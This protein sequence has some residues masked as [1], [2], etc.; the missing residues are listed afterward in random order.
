MDV[1]SSGRQ[2]GNTK[3]LD[4]VVAVNAHYSVLPTEMI[5]HKYEQFK[6]YTQSNTYFKLLPLFLKFSWP[7]LFSF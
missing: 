7:K 5:Q 6:Q 4:Q 2:K 1:E 3:P